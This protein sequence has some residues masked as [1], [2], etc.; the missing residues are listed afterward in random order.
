MA[1]S[2]EPTPKRTEDLIIECSI[3]KALNIIGGS[4]LSL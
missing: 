2:N 4:G 3:E 1:I